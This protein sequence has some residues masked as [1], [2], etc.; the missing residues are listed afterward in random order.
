MVTIVTDS[1]ADLGTE[2]AK[3]Y[4]VHVV[5]MYVFVNDRSYLDGV[6]ISLPELFQSVTLTGKLPKTSAPTV[7]DFLK[8]FELPGEIVYVGLSSKLSATHQ[9][10]L[11]AREMAGAERIFPVDTLNLSTGIGLLVIKAAELR[12][13]GLSGAEIQ[14]Q[15]QAMAH[16]VRTSFI[17]ETLDY[18][19]KGGRCSAMQNLVGSLLQ[20]RPVIAVQPDGTLG[21]KTKLRGTRK[22]ALHAMLDDFA[23]NAPKVAL[24]RVFVS[25]AGCEDDAQYVKAELLRIAPIQEVLITHLGSVIAS[26]C[27]PDTLGILYR[28]TTENPH[29]PL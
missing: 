19:Y 23:E 16:G 14:Q 7:R 13:Q 26:H 18:L 25:H 5:P 22:K 12:D 28:L 21:I 2:L 20:I 6:D 4:N 3:R 15:V 11:L 8:V 9:N 29:E 1:T 10:A 27:G 17:V 24:E